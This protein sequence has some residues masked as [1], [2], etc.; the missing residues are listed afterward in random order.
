MVENKRLSVNLPLN[1]HFYTQQLARESNITL[2]NWITSAIL[3]KMI[4]DG[5]VE[6]VEQE[7]V[8][9]LRFF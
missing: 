9:K 3:E 8:D 5:D 2:T 1:L 6:V 7:E 4:R